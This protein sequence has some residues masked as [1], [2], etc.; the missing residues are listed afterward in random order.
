[1]KRRS[2]DSLVA[3]AVVRNSRAVARDAARWSEYSARSRTCSTGVVS[4]PWSACRATWL[5]TGRTRVERHGP[6]PPPS[7][8]L[9]C[10]DARCAPRHTTARSHTGDR[11]P[12]HVHGHGP[13]ARPRATAGGGGR[14]CAA[15]PGAPAGSNG[16][17]KV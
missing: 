16:I 8:G 5:Y 11:P 14:G 13:R 17:L 9:W 4:A 1:M 10:V 15:W 12:A 2:L 6:R 3:G 7:C